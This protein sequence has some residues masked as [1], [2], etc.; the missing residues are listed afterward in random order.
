MRRVV[1]V[2]CS[3]HTLQCTQCQQLIVQIESFS[4]SLPPSLT[5]ACTDCSSL[6][7]T[8]CYVPTDAVVQLWSGGHCL[9]LSCTP[10]T[11]KKR[12]KWRHY[13]FTQNLCRRLAIFWSNYQ[14]PRLGHCRLPIKISIISPWG[15]Q[16]NMGVHNL[17]FKFFPM[18]SLIM[19]RLLINF[20]QKSHGVGY[21]DRVLYS[22]LEVSQ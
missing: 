10:A 1:S 21:F 11:N 7:L 14:H 4:L 8:S 15:Q 5:T 12:N 2:L 9:C 22:E 18:G 19:T 20:W 3:F 13:S 16:K 17:N 6:S